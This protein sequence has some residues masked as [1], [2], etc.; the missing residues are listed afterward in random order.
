MKSDIVLIYNISSNKR[1][2]GETY[3]EHI[4]RMLA[5]IKKDIPNHDISPVFIE[6][7]ADVF[8]NQIGALRKELNCK[9]FSE[10]YL[11][12]GIYRVTFRIPTDKFLALNWNGNFLEYIE[13][14]AVYHRN[15]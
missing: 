1:K 8:K 6:I 2:K 5:N 4:K 14:P 11:S 10:E 12:R 3:S 15:L 13:F 9:F 7:S